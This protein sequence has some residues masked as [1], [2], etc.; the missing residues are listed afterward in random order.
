VRLAIPFA[1]LSGGPG[2][3]EGVSLSRAIEQLSSGVG[4]DGTRRFLDAYVVRSARR[5][6]LRRPAP[7]RARRR[8]HGGVVR[9][10]KVA[11]ARFLAV[12]MAR[13]G[14]VLLAEPFDG[15]HG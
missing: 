2:A 1:E 7:H 12:W 8:G 6:Q 13:R 15:A 11:E 9:V 14:A 4:S 10:G 3:S 5:P